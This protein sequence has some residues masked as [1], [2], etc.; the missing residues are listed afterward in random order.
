MFHSVTKCP[1]LAKGDE[2]DLDIP[3][4]KRVAMDELHV[5]TGSFQKLHQSCKK[6]FPSIDKWAKKCGAMQQGYHSGTFTGG[7]VKKMLEKIGI[8]ENM[9]R[10]ESNMIAMRFVSAFRALDWVRKACF[11]TKLKSDWSE[12]LDEF[13]RQITDLVND[14]EMDMSCTIK[15]QFII[16]H[17]REHCEDELEVRPEAP[18][19]LGRVSK[20]TPES[21][22]HKFDKYV[23]R[24]NPH[25]NCPELLRH[26]LERAG[27][28]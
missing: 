7:D 16:I 15:F 18:R 12:A 2:D 17:V 4:R 27:S 8:L 9:A 1:I 14:F 20:Q 23:E 25:W 26:E 10:E 28:S 3:V 13:Q 19:G 24:F 6:H 5:M 22:H 21:M 11:S